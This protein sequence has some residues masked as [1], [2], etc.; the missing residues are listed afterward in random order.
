MIGQLKPA[1]KVSASYAHVQEIAIVIAFGLFA[2][3]NN[4]QIL[5]S[6][7]VDFIHFEPGDGDRDFII[8][9]A[10]TLD[11]ERWIIFIL[12]RAACCFE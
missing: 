9:L 7:N 12:R 3:G 2:A 1:F 11:I 8:V 6:N 4:Q 5:L 10:S